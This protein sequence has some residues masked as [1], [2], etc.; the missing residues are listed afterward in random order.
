M[1]NSWNMMKCLPPPVMLLRSYGKDDPI[2][3]TMILHNVV[4]GHYREWTM[5]DA[6]PRF[7]V[8]QTDVGLECYAMGSMILQ[9]FPCLMG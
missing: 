1:G 6:N 2:E 4:A 8:V 9:Y 5:G 7:G 3:S